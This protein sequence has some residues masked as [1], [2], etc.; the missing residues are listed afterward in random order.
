MKRIALVFP[1]T[2]ALTVMPPIGLGI[3]AAILRRRGFEP[4]II[5]LAVRRWKMPRLWRHW[6]ENPPDAVGI[7]IMTSNDRG[8]P[9]VAALVR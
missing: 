3:L 9:A 4:E 1:P 5:D 2:R 7:S 6:Q 8:A